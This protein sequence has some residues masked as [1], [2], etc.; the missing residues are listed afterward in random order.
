MK[1]MTGPSI[2]SVLSLN[3]DLCRELFDPYNVFEETVWNLR[4]EL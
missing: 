4:A 1:I 3:L 2:D